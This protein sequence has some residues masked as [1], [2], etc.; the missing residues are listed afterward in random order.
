MLIRALREKNEK[1]AGILFERFLFDPRPLFF[2]DLKKREL[3]SVAEILVKTGHHFS[4][5]SD[6]IDRECE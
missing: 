2:A 4:S 6:A 5:S 3:I 1:L